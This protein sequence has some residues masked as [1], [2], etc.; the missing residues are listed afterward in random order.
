M[1]IRLNYIL[2]LI[3]GL[4]SSSIIYSQALVADLNQSRIKNSSTNTFTSSPAPVTLEQAR[5]QLMLLFNLYRDYSVSIDTQSFK[6]VYVK[7]KGITTKDDESLNDETFA[8]EKITPVSFS[9]YLEKMN[10]VIQKRLIKLKPE[11]TAE[12]SRLLGGLNLL[13]SA[14]C[15]ADDNVQAYFVKMKD[16]DGNDIMGYSLDSLRKTSRYGLVES[17]RE[18]YARIKKDQVFGYINLCG[19]EVVICQY[20]KA[21]PFNNGRALVKRVDWYFVDSKNEE[22]ESLDNV[23]D[24]KSLGRGVSWVKMINNKQ[25]LIDNSY[26]VSKKTMTQ[27]YDAIEPFY[28]NTVY[29]VRNGKKFG[30]LDIDGKT[31][32]DVMYD[33]IE[34]SNLSGVYKIHQNNSIGLIDS[35]WSIRTTPVYESISEFNAFGL[36][37]AKTPKGY[38]LIQKKTF[39]TSKFYQTIGEFNEYGVATISDDAKNYGLIDAEMKVIVEPKYVSIGVFNEL[40]LAPACYPNN[41]C[42]FIKYDG[43]EQ[44]KAEYESVGSFNKFGL[45]VART[46]IPNCGNKNNEKCITE[47]VLDKNGNTIIPTTDESI[48]GKFHYELTDSLH[49]DRY[50]IVKVLDDN[51]KQTPKFM[52]VEKDNLQLITATSYDAITASDLHGVFRVRKGELWGLVDTT[53]KILTKPIYR[54]IR[55]VGEAYYAAENALGKWGFLKSNGKPQIPFEYDEVKQYRFGLAPV[56]KG[57]NKWGLISRFNAKLV[58]CEFK[59]VALNESETKF[60]VTDEDGTVYII[61]DK[62]ECETNSL[63]FEQIR[64]KANKQ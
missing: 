62:G 42:G 49:S 7:S 39:K 25:T 32:L 1:K 13:A 63:K 18:G 30:L 61:N 47:I 3:G 37:I 26:D 4:F 56:S 19:D 16:L 14:K 54:E 52:I 29:R 33:N 2:L 58:P 5:K 22:S 57:K 8:E 60:E 27:L 21:E 35:S 59:S 17:Y 12:R 40:G 28:Q 11:E 38:T 48:K 43:S 44:I 6:G 20:E 9:T 64:A 41:K 55:R 53:S 34:P 46:I 36:A 51:T 45:A 24:G 23:I 10:S 15:L 31:K 50:I